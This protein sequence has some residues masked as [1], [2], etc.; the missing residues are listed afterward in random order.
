M[1]KPIPT[2]LVALVDFCAEQETHVSLTACHV[3]RS[4]W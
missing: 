2:H 4:D 3:R 1:S